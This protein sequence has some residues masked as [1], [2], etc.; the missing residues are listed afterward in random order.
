MTQDTLLKA[1]EQLLLA[2][3]VG[4]IGLAVRQLQVISRELRDL[5]VNL[6][7]LITQVEE[8]GRRLDRFED[9]LLDS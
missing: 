8:H 5:Q 2:G 6:A 3:I 9:Q 4:G 1:V 7:G